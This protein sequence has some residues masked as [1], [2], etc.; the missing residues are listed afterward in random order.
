MLTTI[1]L[2]AI[3]AIF[4][5]PS[6]IWLYALTDVV[7]NEFYSISIKVVWLVLLVC[8]PPIA[9]IFYFLIGRNQRKTSYRAGKV[10]TWLIFLI[11]LL[12][13]LFIC[14]QYAADFNFQPEIPGSIRI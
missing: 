11:P 4:V 12:T 9:T 6:I 14:F 10:V 2:M 1:F 5:L 7:L 3:I 8:I 13:L